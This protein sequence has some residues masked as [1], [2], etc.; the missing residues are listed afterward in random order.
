MVVN[1]GTCC[2]ADFRNCAL[3]WLSSIQGVFIFVF[4]LLAEETKGRGEPTI[5]GVTT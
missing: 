1:G 3:D 5:V 4:M 2:A